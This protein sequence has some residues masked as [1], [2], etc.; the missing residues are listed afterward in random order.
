MRH[1]GRSF[2]FVHEHLR[3]LAAYVTQLDLAGVWISYALL[4]LFLGQRIFLVGVYEENI[5]EHKNKLNLWKFV[6]KKI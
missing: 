6:M 1:L 2:A 3:P 5:L 4:A